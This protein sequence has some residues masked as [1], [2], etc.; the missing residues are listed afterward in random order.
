MTVREM[1]RELLNYDMESEVLIHS[2]DKSGW[3]VT[4]KEIGD[5]YNETVNP[6]LE[7]EE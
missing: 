3:L 2:K 1:I 7:G 4:P 5:F 6:V